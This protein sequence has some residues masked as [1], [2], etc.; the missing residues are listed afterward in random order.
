MRSS[1][2]LWPLLAAL[3]LIV[4]WTDRRLSRA[5]S[6]RYPPVNELVVTENYIRDL[7][8]LL[9][10]AHRLAAD[11]AYVDFLQ[12][13]GT[14]DLEEDIGPASQQRRAELKSGHPRLLELG[15]R[16]L[17]L[18]PYFNAAILEAAGSIAFN[19]MRVDEALTL[20]REAI[21][22]DP[23]FFRYHLYVSA[24]L[25]KEKGNVP[26]L[27]N[28][29]LEAIKYPDCPPLLELVLANLLKKVGR[30][31]DAARVYIHTHTTA[32]KDY[33]RND[34]LRRLK[35]LVGEHPE[36]GPQLANELPRG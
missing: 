1:R 26:G 13:Y 22:R 20:L 10:G 8:A 12:Y 14:G 2:A 31:M 32:A 25:Y 33:E 6:W 35:I 15:T 18:D 36:L 23:S 28:L 24:I 11:V 30:Y 19:Q 29:L 21:E 3:I 27:I 5:L 16:I 17:R 7:G 4:V 9:F 34:A